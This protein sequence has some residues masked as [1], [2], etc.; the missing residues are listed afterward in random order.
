MRPDRRSSIVARM[1]P[2]SL[3]TLLVILPSR[4]ATATP[5]SASPATDPSNPPATYMKLEM[6]TP[7]QG[8]DFGPYLASVFK[9]I[10][11]KWSLLTPTS[12]AKGE[13]GIVVVQFRIQ[14]DGK[15]PT[16]NS[17]FGVPRS[18][19][20]PLDTSAMGA[21]RM[22]APFNALP[23]NFTGPY[24][25]VRVNFFYNIPRDKEPAKK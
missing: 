2:L 17:E 15:V 13:Q 21:V 4:V 18:G 12:V 25:D 8:V 5:Q 22:S 16:E 6:M 11:S 24:V 19:K 14:Q 20:N 1:L 3:V 10:R 7:D 9:A 23:T